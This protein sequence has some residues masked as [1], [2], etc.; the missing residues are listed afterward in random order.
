MTTVARIYRPAHIQETI[1]LGGN[2]ISCSESSSAMLADAV[3]L[4]AIKVTQQWI[5]AHSSEPIPNPA[6]PGLNI[7]QCLA[8]L[9]S[10]QIGGL[11]DATGQTWPQA[12]ARLNEDRRLLLQVDM[13][14]LG[15]CNSAKVGHMIHVQAY[16]KGRGILVNDPMCKAAHWLRPRDVRAAAEAFAN[17]TGVPGDGIRFAYSR[18][19]PRVAVNT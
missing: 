10:L 5:R 6:S 14:R 8:V 17:A 16:R 11:V 7:P 9:R 15:S 19:V 4:G 13:S 2:L 18:R 1:R 3:T 12:F